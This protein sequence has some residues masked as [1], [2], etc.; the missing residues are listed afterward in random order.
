MKKDKI[1]ELQD[2][3][4]KIGMNYFLKH[5]TNNGIYIGRIISY[6]RYDNILRLYNLKSFH[7]ILIDLNDMSI[8][9]M[10]KDEETLREHKEKL[11]L[12]NK[13]R[14]S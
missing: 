8:I 5:V 3:N 1:I 2:K 11:W 4:L 14:K 10:T 7:T 12:E 9:K 6:N 13:N